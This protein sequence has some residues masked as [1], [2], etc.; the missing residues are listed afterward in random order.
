MK[1]KKLKLKNIRS[2]VDEEI[3]FPEGSFLLSG[4]VGAGKTSI[5]LAIEYALFGLQPGQR[6]TSLLRS[7]RAQSEVSL[8]LEINGKTVIIERK[9]KRTQKGVSNE[10][11]AITL[12]GEKKE[13]SATE[14]KSKIVDLLGYPPEFVKKNNI[15]YRYTVYTPQEEMK[16]IILEDPETRLNI[17]RHIFG[18]NKYRVV[19]NNLS[20]IITHIKNQS[21]FLQGEINSLEQDKLDLQKR[22]ENLILT[23]EK[24]ALSEKQFEEKSLVRKVQEKELREL[25]EKLSEKFKLEKE[26]E[27]TVLMINSKRENSN[28]QVREIEE[29]RKIISLAGD[30]VNDSELIG[31]LEKIK[32]HKAQLDDMNSKYYQ[33]ISAMRSLELEREEMMV[34]KERVF[35]I[36]ICPTCLQDVSDSH[37]HNILSNTEQKLAAIK[38]SLADLQLQS[39]DFLSKLQGT[40]KDLSEIEERKSVLEIRKSRQEQIERSKMKIVQL[41]KIQASLESDVLLLTA[42]LDSLKE[43]IF[44]HSAFDLQYKRKE[45]EL[46]QAFIEEK[47]AEISL[48]EF[49]K[50]KQFVERE[51]DLFQSIIAKKE[52]AKKKLYSFVELTDWLSNAFLSLIDI[53]ERNVLLKV[54]NEFSSL[55]RKWFFILVSENSFDCQLDENFTP[56]IMQGEAELEYDFLSGGERTAVALAYRLALN[57]IINSLMSK[58]KTKGIIILDEPTDGFSEA[59]ISKI[60]DILEEINADQL[61]IVSHEQK[62][63]SFVDN[64]IRVVKEGD[65]SKIERA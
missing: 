40:K 7:D 37:K 41:E 44:E 9:L 2:Y 42:H 53:A 61:I 56:I 18:I 21:K 20:I 45:S 62:V 35:K 33:S 48:A 22:K 6:G 16:Q 43:K 39:S 1:F 50:E 26:V 19:K 8:E 15:L 3:I 36:Q 10:Y 34:K 63:E 55:F 12:D 32:I 54:R 25:E 64:I 4:D 30:S 23:S 47:K 60:R 14:I 38:N 65:S 57:Q 11:A 31:V 24:V 5:L 59:Q 49:K 28:S 46:K 17:L 13:S 29:L 27:K 51:I 58:I 52:E